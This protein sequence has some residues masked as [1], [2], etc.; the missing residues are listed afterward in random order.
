MK[1]NLDNFNYWETCLGFL[2]STNKVHK[3]GK[4]YRNR[5]QGYFSK[6][7]P[8]WYIGIAG[9][10]F[11]TKY[12]QVYFTNFYK[13]NWLLPWH[14]KHTQKSKVT[15]QQKCAISSTVVILRKLFKFILTG[16]FH[17]LKIVLFPYVKRYLCLNYVSVMC[18]IPQKG[19]HEAKT[20]LYRHGFTI[21]Q[22]C[23]INNAEVN[24][25]CI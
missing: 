4:I 14:F 13:M 15:L 12:W 5:S 24:R 8:Y 23:F 2:N 11:A 3:A 18:T 9:F 19:R 25:I 1:E 10:G 21:M 6:I 22:Y 20:W 7:I 16:F 17:E